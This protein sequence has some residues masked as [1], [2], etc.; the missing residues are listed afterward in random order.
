[1]KK[2]FVFFIFISLCSGIQTSSQI[3]SP[4]YASKPEKPKRITE[5]PDSLHRQKGYFN[6]TQAGIGVRL[7]KAVISLSTVNGYQFSRHISLGLGVGYSRTCLPLWNSWDILGGKMTKSYY[8]VNVDQLDL[9]I[10]NRVFLGRK[11]S[12]FLLFDL[13]YSFILYPGTHIL[14]SSEKSEYR[15]DFPYTWPDTLG[16]IN[17]SGRIYLAPGFGMRVFIH[18]NLAL[19][20][21]LQLYVSG[22]LITQHYNS[23]NIYDPYYSE[24]KLKINLY[25][26]LTIGIGF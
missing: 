6:N 26:L 15:S 24:N 19:N 22:Y 13:G 14:T 7:R 9:F 11:K 10:E 23:Q 25:P 17:Y 4:D 18:R 5:K 16:K 20:F 12:L 8:V 3:L 2:T 21:S 1:M